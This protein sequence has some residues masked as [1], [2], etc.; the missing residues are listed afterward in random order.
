[1]GRFFTEI[2]HQIAE[3][4]RKQD[5]II[6]KVAIDTFV[7]LQ[8]KTPVDSGALRR[9]WT[10]AINHIPTVF[11]SSDDPKEYIAGA[12]WGD[13]IVIATDKPY[14]P[15][16]EYGLYPSPSKTGKTANGFSIQAP[17]GMVRITVDEMKAYLKRNPSL[18]L[19]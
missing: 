10:V 16:L 8:K 13:F 15:M 11:D 9:S 17:K 18:G 19:S 1:M 7:K 14:A 12:K 6:R 5:Q 4:E 3:I 2:Q